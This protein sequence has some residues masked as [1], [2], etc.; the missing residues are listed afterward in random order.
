[1]LLK[2]LLSYWPRDR[3][4]SELADVSFKSGFRA[5]VTGLDSSARIYFQAGL[6]HKLHRPALVITPDAVRAEKVY[7]DLHAFYPAGQINLLPSRELFQTPDVLTHSIE[8][9]QQRLLFLEWLNQG[10][11]GFFV[12]PFTA[13]I[14]KMVPPDLWRSLIL[15]IS[16]EQ[17]ADRDNL[18]MRLIEMGYERVPL[19]EGKGQC[20]G[21]GDIIDVYPFGREQPL[22]IVLFEDTVESIRLFDPQ[23]QR[24]AEYLQSAGILPAVELPLP[25][26]FFKRGESRM[27]HDTEQA[28]AGLRR[29]GEAVTASRLKASVEMHLERLARPGGLDFI[30]GYFSYFFGSGAAL[31][32]YLPPEF[33][34]YLDD[35]MSML[36]KSA[37]LRRELAE[38][39]GNLYLQGELLQGRLDPLW[40]EKE[41]FAR[42]PCAVVA[43]NSFPGLAGW[44]DPQCE[45]QIESKSV[46]SY[47]GQWDLLENDFNNWRRQGYRV[48]FLAGSL[49]R[50]TGLLKSLQEYGLPVSGVPG[51][52]WE[53][54]PTAPVQLVATSLEEG[55]I[56]P[57]IGMVVV[58]EHNLVPRRRKKKRLSHKDGITLRDYRDL[59]VGDYVVHE[60]HGI[61][62]YLGVKTMEIKGIQRDY[63]LIKYSGTDKLYIPADQI[64]L[65]QK[66]AGS[67]GR[68]PR[69]HSLGSGEWHRL[70]SKVKSSIQEM[71][72]ELLSLYAARQ[73]VGGYSFGPDH[74][75]QLEFEARFPYEETPDQLQAIAEVKADMEKSHPMDRLICGDVG[76]G[77]TEVALRAAF[78]AAMEGKQVALLVPTTILAQQHYR[79]F[80]ERFAEFPLQIAQLSRFVSPLRQKEI[81][82]DLARGRIDIIIG[83]HRLL[84]R[85]IRFHDLGMLIIDEEQRFG[86]RHKERLKQLRLDVDVLAMTA[87]P[88][89]R[90]LHLSLVG[91]RD[92]SVIETPPEDRYPVQTYVAEYSELLVKEVIQRELSRQGQ[93]YFVF[94][95]VDGIKAIAKN[96]QALFPG[97]PV[98]VGHGQMPEADLERTMSEF[99][100][101]RYK[102]LISTTIIEAGLDIPNV[103]TLIIYD[104]DKFGLA[105]LYQIRGRVGRSNRV[106]YAYLTY[107]KEKIISETARKRLQAIK[108]FT[109]LGSG[110]KVALRD[111]EIRGAG[112]ILGAEQHGHVTAVGFDF[113][114]RLLEQA[115]AGL[116]NEKRE[117]K[118]APRLDLEVDAYIPASY[119]T[120][121]DQKIDFYYR[122]YTSNVEEDLS[123]IEVEMRDRYGTPPPAV[124]NLLSVANLRVLAQE[125]GVELIEQKGSLILIKFD[126]A[127]KF[128]SRTLWPLLNS[129]GVKVTLGTGSKI[130]LK[131]KTEDKP[132]LVMP[133]LI[134]LLK[135]LSGLK[136]EERPFDPGII[137]KGGEQK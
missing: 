103:N 42:A 106:A 52:P 5:A 124:L 136:S 126:A 67:E 9:R 16:L 91:A 26:R 96:I 43:C 53:D 60:Q 117:E 88:I 115:V 46:F 101:G 4:F 10:G 13:V 123:E 68:P 133:E 28:V 27:R 105:Q 57:G 39:H 108:E 113:Y 130:S 12:A 82:A 23:S 33:I 3:Q 21:R 127:Q 102:I 111:L 66:F 76:Y 104:A 2:D 62:K 69:L 87:T 48:C 94:N 89:P 55:F 15:E 95:R 40:D 132:S 122:I 19:I 75:W 63:L 72:G 35:P 70:K 92:L 11:E 134:Q 83:T 58:T 50:G 24:S 131:L 54:N 97:V 125:L 6:A 80:Q 56:M 78:K 109:E 1:M 41:L 77:K 74:P 116:K 61:G 7:A 32:D 29:S 93:V 73:A 84:S 100:D 59:S 129:T 30:P 44:L 71:A 114:C 38:H 85:D 128:E 86:V 110:F 121:Q 34:V 99:L 135:K 36:E 45:V 47:H 25:E 98:A 49:E 64:E 14:S 118:P 119:I 18:L 65:I 51:R 81:I 8:Q 20:S 79:T 31:I 90:T 137:A 112:N 37:V 22:R 120:S 17:K 107:R